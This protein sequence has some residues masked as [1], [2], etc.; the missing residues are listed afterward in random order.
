M[1]PEFDDFKNFKSLAEQVH[2]LNLSGDF[3]EH[4]SFDKGRSHFTSLPFLYAAKFFVKLYYKPF[5]K[6]FLIKQ[7]HLLSNY[8]N[9]LLTFFLDISS[10]L[11]MD[12]SEEYES[13][14]YDV[15]EELKIDSDPIV[16]SIN[17]ILPISDRTDIWEFIALNIHTSPLINLAILTWSS[18]YNETYTLVREEDKEEMAEIQ[19][20]FLS[21]LFKRTK[22]EERGR[23][24]STALNIFE[25]INKFKSVGKFLTT[26]H[27]IFGA[28]PED[29]VGYVT[30]D[31]VS[32]FN[33]MFHIPQPGTK[34]GFYSVIDP[35]S[36]RAFNDLKPYFLKKI[37]PLCVKTKG[38]KIVKVL[39][40]EDLY[41][42]IT[43]LERKTIAPP[44]ESTQK[45]IIQLSKTRKAFTKVEAKEILKQYKSRFIDTLCNRQLES[46]NV[47]C[48]IENRINSNNVVTPEYAFI[49]TI[50]DS[51]GLLTLAFE[52]SEDSRCSYIFKIPKLSW[53][54]SIDLIFDFF[55]S[56]S[57]NKRQAMA[58]GKIDLRLPGNYAYTRVMHNDFFKW[59]EHIKYD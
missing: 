26:I 28:I 56:N 41:D 2:T 16:R 21:Y 6:D 7:R 9:R 38:G 36:K 23:V 47:V 17:P 32:F 5:G 15:C 4:L 39:N 44:K 12:M 13:D 54:R 50:R 46:Y 18:V 57:V 24:L 49:F 30:W 42:C 34:T 27:Q 1:K 53:Q 11:L 14:I 29:G 10:D 31:K 48:C 51:S 35:R 3:S 8:Q 25:T 43:M 37:P 22:R 19:R 20:D 59:L 45:Q 52:N 33:G 58:Q 40:K 55:S